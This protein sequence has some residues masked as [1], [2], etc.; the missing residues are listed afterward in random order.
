MASKTC[1]NNLRVSC[2]FRV[3]KLFTA[4]LPKRV[5]KTHTMH[6]LSSSRQDILVSI[7]ASLNA[8]VKLLPSSPFRLSPCFLIDVRRF[9]SDSVLFPSS[10][11]SWAMLAV[12]ISFFNLDFIGCHVFNSWFDIRSGHIY[13]QGQYF[14]YFS[15]FVW[16][17]FLVMFIALVV[18][19][20]NSFLDLRLLSLEPRLFLY[21]P[22]STTWSFRLQ[23]NLVSAFILSWLWWILRVLL[24]NQNWGN[25]LN[26]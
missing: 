22:H 15:P 13:F 8:L 9:L 7:M 1:A 4:V 2:E 19:V 16:S 24:A 23:F 17:I 14:L 10:S 25:I 20:F 12:S 26:E 3:K 18:F 11:I 5:Y 21:C 6:S